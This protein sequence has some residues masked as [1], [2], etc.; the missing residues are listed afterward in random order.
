[1]AGSLMAKG[2]D[3]GAF[4]GFDIGNSINIDTKWTEDG[5]KKKEKETKGKTTTILVPAEM[6]YGLKGG[7]THFFNAYVG[8][9]AY[10]DT[11]YGFNYMR[12][13]NGPNETDYKKSHW[14][15]AA[16]IDLLINFFDA[17]S[18]TV[19]MF[20]GVGIGYASYDDT[21]IKTEQNVTTTTSFNASGLFLPSKVGLGFGFGQHKIDLAIKI[22]LNDL[23]GKFVN[24]DGQTE[25]LI[26][27][28]IPLLLSY[29]YTF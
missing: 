13:L 4:I 16:N 19:G 20:I 28:F 22:P 6:I 10:A 24:K 2:G 9:R 8:L 1:M 18:V 11:H 23:R 14:D 5:A 26:H 17:S 15:V 3:G 27:Y 7:Y 29:S 21:T 12:V 25:H